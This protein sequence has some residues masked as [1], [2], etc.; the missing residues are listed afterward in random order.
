MACRLRMP[1]GARSH[2]SLSQH[3]TLILK[4]AG[5][6]QPIGLPFR[7]ACPVP[8]VFLRARML[9]DLS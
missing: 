5:L 3:H 1:A 7:P 9:H 4:L 2:V 8:P 6:G